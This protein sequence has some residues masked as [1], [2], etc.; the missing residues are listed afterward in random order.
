MWSILTDKSKN[1]NN[2]SHFYEKTL[3]VCI[4]FVHR[5]GIL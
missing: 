2:L 3:F 1:N 5:S 4:P